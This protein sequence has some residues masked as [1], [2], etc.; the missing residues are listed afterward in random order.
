MPLKIAKMPKEK[1]TVKTRYRNFSDFFQQNTG[2]HFFS[3]HSSAFHLPHRWVFEVFFYR[4]L[5]RILI[6]DGAIRFSIFRIADYALSASVNLDVVLNSIYVQRIFNPYHILQVT[7]KII[8]FPE[9]F[10]IIFFLSP[11]KQLFDKDVSFDESVYLSQ[12]LTDSILYIE[13]KKI[14][15]LFFE[16]EIDHVAYHSSYNILKKRVRHFYKMKKNALQKI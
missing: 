2:V 11:Y 8:R 12:N 6:I 7:E 1:N 10:D 3:S 9:S 15:V 4:D 13:K 5:T 16:K 14:P